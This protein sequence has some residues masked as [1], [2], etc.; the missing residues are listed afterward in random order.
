MT[1][2]RT[3]TTENET[4][5]RTISVVGLQISQAADELGQAAQ[6]L[7]D[8]ESRVHDAEARWR[9]AEEQ[10]EQ[11]ATKNAELL[12]MVRT[13]REGQTE[14]DERNR[15]TE[16][17]L[18]I[19]IERSRLLEEQVAALE[20]RVH[21]AEATPEVTLVLDDERM[22]LHEAI[23]GEVRRPLTS[24]MGL[25]LALKHADPRSNEGA[26]MVKQLAANARK[27]DRLVGE[28]T[29]IEKIATGAFEPN[30][31]R[32][33][34]EALVRRV[35]EESPDVQDRDVVFE[36]EHVAMEIDR[37]L[38][39]QMIEMLLA[40]AGRRTTPGN[41]VWV[42]LSEG[43]DGAT[44]SVQDTGPDIPAGLR[45]AMFAASSEQG[46]V[47]RR[48]P[49][50][51]TGL[52]LLARFATLQAGRA[53]VEPRPGGGASFCVFLPTFATTTGDDDPGGREDNVLPL[54]REDRA[55]KRS[56]DERAAER[57]RDASDERAI[58][59]AKALI[60]A[61]DGDDDNE[62]SIFGS[63]ANGHRRD[64]VADR[65]AATGGPGS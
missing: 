39:E 56:I 49:R 19:A 20:D 27:L 44:I 62:L 13:A 16:Q 58:A 25:T 41:P 33:D 61:D 1:E 2:K 59:L 60:A 4:L 57:V 65:L 50:G 26:D 3:D 43:A 47:A 34:L 31:R 9:V 38:V 18:Q 29:D 54:A 30:L 45:G 6:R 51:A 23:A 63:I 35:V 10:V 53:W 37:A 14:A 42:K 5:A 36:T 55:P 22:A 24:I 52:S 8:A 28:M 64:A 15:R 17:R 7:I 32:T 12:E 21:E 40:N 46:P 11:G 48:K